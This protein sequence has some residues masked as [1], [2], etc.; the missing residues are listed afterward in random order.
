MSKYDPNIKYGWDK[1]TQFLLN[2]D[3]FG[4]ILNTFRTVLATTEAQKILLLNN[5]NNK[6]EEILERNV[7]TGNVKPAITPETI[8]TEAAPMEVVAEEDKQ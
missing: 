6:M 7:H 8:P 1:D 3:E 2:G 4:L 5:A